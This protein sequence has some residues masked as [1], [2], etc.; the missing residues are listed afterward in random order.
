MHERERRI[1]VPVRLHMR[2]TVVGRDGRAKRISPDVLRAGGFTRRLTVVDLAIASKQSPGAP[3]L[4]KYALRWCGSLYP[5]G[6]PA[7]HCHALLAAN[8]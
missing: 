4:V 8:A 1:P 3:A 5:P 7:G 6:Q 2:L